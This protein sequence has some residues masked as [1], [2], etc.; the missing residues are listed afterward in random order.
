[1]GEHTKGPWTLETVPTS[2]GICHKIGQFPWKEGK[3]RSAC[4]Y[5]DYPGS[6]EIEAELLANARLI[7][8]A[9]ELA[10]KVKRLE[11]QNAALLAV[12]K[13]L[14]ADWDAPNSDSGIGQPVYDA[15]RAAIAA[16]E[17]SRG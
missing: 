12:A 13:A 1:M 6:G 5:V 11:E 16:N 3:T 15:A 17:V 2:C 7:A 9:P 4:I 10:D 8:S 14:V